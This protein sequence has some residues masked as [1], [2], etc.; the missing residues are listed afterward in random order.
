MKIRLAN[1]NELKIIQSYAK[2]VQ[3]E[4]TL[5]YLSKNDTPINKNINYSGSN[6]FVLLNN[7]V[8]NGWILIGEMFN[9]YTM[10]RSGLISELYILPQFR[11]NGLG[12]KLMKF[13]I[14]HFRQ[15]NYKT[16]HLN[17]FKGNPALDL[18]KKMGFN[19]I[20]IAMEKQL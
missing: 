4:S 20:S 13:A 8:V 9:P 19:E 7:G 14:S 2:I 16:I 11:K 12:Y 1:A 17:V 6:Y 3:E 10:A 15:K 5:G 18:Y